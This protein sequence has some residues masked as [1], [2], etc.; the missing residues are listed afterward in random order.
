MT[1]ESKPILII[2]G[3]I[4]IASLPLSRWIASEYLRN[5]PRIYFSAVTVLI[6][7]YG[8]DIGEATT[9]FATE[10]SP[11][12]KN[13]EIL[14]PVIEKLDLVKK[15]SPPGTTLPMQWVTESLSRSMVVRVKKN[16]DLIY[17]YPIE[18]GVYNADQ[19]LAAD[20]ANT[21]A[22][23]YRDKR[24][25][26]MRKE[27]EL[28]LGE[29]KDELRT[30]REE[31]ERLSQEALQIRME[32]GIVDPDPDNSAA[33][34]SFAVERDDSSSQH[35]AQVDEKKRTNRYRE[36]KVTCLMTKLLLVAMQ[37]G[38]DAKRS[39]IAWLEREKTQFPV[40]IWK[41]A[42]PSQNPALPDSVLMLR[43]ANV[44][45]GSLS[46]IGAL[47]ILIALRI[48]SPVHMN[49]HTAT[50]AGSED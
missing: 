26:D 9:Q 1:S 36:K 47:L 37:Q 21:I 41:R 29:R 12:I 16:T 11:K 2:V 6:K 42:Q 17:A 20:I 18:I 5:A 43:R 48:K 8:D 33:I 24:S 35:K 31:M 34:L 27:T 4:L 49:T 19:Q 46:A 50:N 10:L 32:D 45:G 7:R 13:S 38:C 25:E 14:I 30:K 22:V 15:L 40:E 3:A 23:A 39:Q 28:A 44:I